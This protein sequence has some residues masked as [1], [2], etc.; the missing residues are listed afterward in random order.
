MTALRAWRTG[1]RGKARSRPSS[2]CRSSAEPAAGR[3]GSPSRAAPP[4]SLGERPGS[5]GGTPSAPL[6]P[7]RG[8]VGERGDVTG[9]GE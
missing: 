5:W 2:S 7:R 6:S 1:T 9:V 4:M 3:A 8:S